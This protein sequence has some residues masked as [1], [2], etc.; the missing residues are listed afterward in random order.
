M[1]LIL[2]YLQFTTK[3]KPIWDKNI[4]K[5][6]D[7]M[8][9]S[10]PKFPSPPFRWPKT[11]MS[12]LQPGL[13]EV[14]LTSK[15]YVTVTVEPQLMGYTPK[16]LMAGYPKWCFGKTPFEHGNFYAIFGIY[17]RFLGCKYFGFNPQDVSFREGNPLLNRDHY[18]ILWNWN[19]INKHYQLVKT[20]IP[21]I[22]RE[23]AH[24]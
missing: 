4:H 12:G 14:L 11:E 19:P 10:V 22:S 20:G 15:S 21:K 2:I 3:T 18:K 16:K 5:Y 7:P 13:L 9:F 17:V 24:I 1:Y 8:G 23:K 6:M